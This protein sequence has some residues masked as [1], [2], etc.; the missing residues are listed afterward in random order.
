MLCTD[1]LMERPSATLDGG[2]DTLRVIL[3]ELNLTTPDLANRLFR[4]SREA[5][6]RRDD[7]AILT[8]RILGTGLA[9]AERGGITC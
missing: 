6:R 2:F 9:G 8:V 5:E 1:G 7:V 4:A 3:P